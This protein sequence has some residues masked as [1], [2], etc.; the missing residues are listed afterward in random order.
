MASPIL[1]IMMFVVVMIIAAVLFTGWVVIMTARWVWRGLVGTS[2]P[3][4]SVSHGVLET[5]M[6][7]QERCHAPNPMHAQ[8]C[9]RCGGAFGNSAS[10]H[11]RV[12]V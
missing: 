11:R 4:R 2:A 1:G 6:C 3:S 7:S 8:F 9:R 12:A 10:A 5:R